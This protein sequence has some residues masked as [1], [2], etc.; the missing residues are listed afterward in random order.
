MK[1]G[2]RISLIVLSVILILSE[3]I[4]GIPFVGGSI[5]LSLGW[6]PLGT[7]MLLYFI[8]IVI[9]L[10]DKQNTIKPMI[11][12]PLLGIVGSLIAFIPVIGMITHWILLVLM[13][14]FLFIVLSTPIYLSDRNARVIY[15]E[16]DKRSKW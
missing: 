7:N 5:I 8:I 4:Y 15:D 11:V 13:G 9:M 14:F 12:I 3:L 6:S 16:K 1:R 10:V 2:I